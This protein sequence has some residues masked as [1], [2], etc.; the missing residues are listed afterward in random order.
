MARHSEI[1]QIVFE[2][3]LTESTERFN[4]YIRVLKFLN[5]VY[6]VDAEALRGMLR[7]RVVNSLFPNYQ[8]ANAVYEAAKEILKDDPYLLQQQANYERIRDNGNLR[9]A[10]SLLEKAREKEPSDS[11]ILHSLA[12]L[13]CA[14]AEQSQKPL[15]RARFRNEARALLQRIEAGAPSGRY[16]V[17]TRLHLATDELRELLLSENT[18]DRAID[19]AVRSGESIIEVA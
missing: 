17:V 8:D 3:V 5:P 16:A 15:E 1:A 6:A 19:E 11:T 13:M 7:A 12:V 9:L 18:A 2:Q 4:E 10:R 14:Q